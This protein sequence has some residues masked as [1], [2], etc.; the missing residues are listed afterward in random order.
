MTVTENSMQGE[1]PV[2]KKPANSQGNTMV[3]QAISL[4][5]MLLLWIGY[6]YALFSGNDNNMSG[7]WLPILA[8]AL[9]NADV[10]LKGEK[11]PNR[12]LNVLAKLNGLLFVVSALIAI[13]LL[14]IK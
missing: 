5:A 13:V 2:L 12:V 11:M 7:Y 1:S 4:I 9:L 8:L 10:M 14:I 3:F 6:Y